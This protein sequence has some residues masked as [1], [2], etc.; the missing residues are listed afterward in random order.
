MKIHDWNEFIDAPPCTALQQAGVAERSFKSSAITLREL[1]KAALLRVHSLQEFQVLQANMAACNIA[2]PA[3]VN[4]CIDQGTTVLCQA[5][6][7]W[8]LFSECSSSGQLLAQMQPALNAQ[9]TVALDLSSALAVFRLAGGAAPWLLGK[10]CGLDLQAGIKTGAHTARTRLQHAAVTLHYHT[11][12][13]PAA[14][15]FSSAVFDLI[16][17]RS[18]APYLWQLLIASTP[19]A[20]QL[21]QLYGDRA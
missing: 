5:P 2:L 16:F 15:V 7:E 14:S 6:G 9:H 17:D 4:E 11:V 13:E 21:N 8:L 12:D 10:L 3:N 1:E 19:H 18:F 20:E